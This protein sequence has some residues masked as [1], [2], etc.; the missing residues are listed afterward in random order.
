MEFRASI[1]RWTRDTESAQE[2]P[3]KLEGDEKMDI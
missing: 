2:K 3:I 1:Q